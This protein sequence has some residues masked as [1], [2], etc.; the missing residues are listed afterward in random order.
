MLCLGIEIRMLA[1]YMSRN[2][3]LFAVFLCPVMG[4]LR[5]YATDEARKQGR[6]QRAA[7]R[8]KLRPRADVY[9][10]KVIDLWNKTKCATGIT[11]DIEFA[12]CLLDRLVIC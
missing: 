7:E 1:V 10:G 6:A 9:L 4:R 5:I 3:W 2:F 12:I 8:R 11:S